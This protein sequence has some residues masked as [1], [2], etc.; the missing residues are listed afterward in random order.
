MPEKVSTD[1]ATD[2]PDKPATLLPR[3]KP[4]P[5]A[6][7][8][9]ASSVAPEAPDVNEFLSAAITNGLTEFGVEPWPGRGSR[10]AQR[11]HRQVL[12]L[13]A[14]PSG[15][16]A[17]RK[18]QGSPRGLYRVEAAAGEPGEATEVRRRRHA[19]GRPTRAGAAVRGGGVRP[20]RPDHGAEGRASHED[21]ADAEGDGRRAAGGSEVLPV[22]RRGLSAWPQAVT[23]TSRAS[24]RGSRRLGRL[25]QRPRCCDCGRSRHRRW[26]C[27]IRLLPRRC[28]S[29]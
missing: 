5:A 23:L 2:V 7:V 12:P 11:L 17:I 21:G 6:P 25:P 20:T 10:E 8:R 13:L 3:F 16:S 26:A 14:E 27:P 1:A 9:P 18:A 19:A 28:S 4:A 22:V 15:V 29:H 24:V